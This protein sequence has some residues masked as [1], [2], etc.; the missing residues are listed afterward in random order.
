MKIALIAPGYK[1]FPPNGWGAV[2]SIVWDYYENLKKRENIEVVIVNTANPNTIIEETNAHDPTI[3][4]VMY[5]D[6]IIVVPYLKCKRIFYTTHYAY[7]TDPHFETKY[8]YYFNNFFKKAIQYQNMITMNLISD[9]LA[10]V[11]VK[12]GFDP[13]RINIL[14]NGAREDL[15]L[16]IPLSPKYPEKSIYLAKIEFRKCQYKYQNIK[17][18]HFVGNYHDSPFERSNPN[19]LGEWD[20]PTLYA[21]LTNYANMV[22]LS[23]GE[24]DPLVIKEALMAG[25]GVVIS[26]CSSANLDKNLPF[27]TIIPN[28]KIDDLKFVESAIISNR[29]ISL[30]NRQA[31]R[32]YALAH[33]SWGK[34]IDQ[35]LSLVTA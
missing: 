16:F 27:I 8:D 17:N 2:E 4:H 26:E 11:Y 25:L 3:V 23:Q 24:A 31:I 6:Y 30:E 29:T 10:A 13:R 22:L 12:H 14:S 1:P 20:K 21:N 32:E 9:K 34:I 33:F 28:E 35:Y 7:I 5:D 18:I 19:Y 15:F